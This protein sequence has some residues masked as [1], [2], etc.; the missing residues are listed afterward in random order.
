MSAIAY[1]LMSGL[2]YLNSKRIFRQ[3][4]IV[5][6][7][8]VVLVIFGETILRKAL[9]KIATLEEK[10]ESIGEIV[11]KGLAAEPEDKNPPLQ[12]S[13]GNE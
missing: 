12:S 3:V 9:R 13:D 7:V 4:E 6:A 10:A 2:H 11:E 5:I 8:V 1:F